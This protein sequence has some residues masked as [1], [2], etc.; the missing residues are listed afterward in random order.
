MQAKIQKWGNSL[1]IR[2]PKSIAT[3]AK[4]GQAAIVELAV[5]KGKLTIAPVKNR[6]FRLKDL[7]AGITEENIHDEDTWGRAVGKEVW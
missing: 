3:E 2:I 4:L 1:A 7:V 6:K 5:A